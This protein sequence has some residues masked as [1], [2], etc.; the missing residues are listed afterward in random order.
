M[1]EKKDIPR[2]VFESWRYEHGYRLTDE[3]VLARIKMNIA[4]R[5]GCGTAILSVLV[6]V[7]LFILLSFI[8]VGIGVLV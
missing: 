2:D 4:L 8:A 6:F 1:L 7:A 5:K 3:Q